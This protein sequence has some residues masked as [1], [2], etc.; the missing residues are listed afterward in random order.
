MVL[1]VLFWVY[2]RLY[3]F[4]DFH[5]VALTFFHFFNYYV[6]YLLCEPSWRGAPR[7]AKLQHL[8]KALCEMFLIGHLRSALHSSCRSPTS[9]FICLSHEKW[10]KG[11][12]RQL[13]MRWVFCFESFDDGDWLLLKQLLL[14]CMLQ[15]SS[16]TARKPV[17]QLRQL[18][19]RTSTLATLNR[20]VVV[21]QRVVLTTAMLYLTPLSRFTGLMTG[22]LS[23]S[24]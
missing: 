11:Y 8:F 24:V 7:E 23:T 19:T 13:G 21:I 6:Q 12:P 9:W 5:H 16:S 22:P 4:Q 18:R 15:A 17:V 3:C 14:F 20:L 2:Y 1:L 10:D